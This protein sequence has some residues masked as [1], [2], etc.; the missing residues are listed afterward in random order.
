MITQGVTFEM[1]NFLKQIY[2]LRNKNQFI[3]CIS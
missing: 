2:I 1:N 3:N